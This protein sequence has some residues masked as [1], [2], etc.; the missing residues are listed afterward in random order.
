MASPRLRFGRH[1]E[2]GYFYS[3]TI[4]TDGRRRWFEDPQNVA[5]I[6]D[7]LRFVE[8]SAYSHSVAWVIMPDHVHWLMQLRRGCL[9]GCTGLL[10]SRSSRLLNQR[11]QRQGKI[12]QHGY[13]DHAVRC[14]ESL[15]RQAFYLL[16]NPVRAGLASALGDYPHAWSRWPMNG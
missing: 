6:I 8:R 10:K 11:L 14:D 3:L 15:R 5:V 16:A 4:V 1:S 13:F 7:T 12:W 9:S 2:A